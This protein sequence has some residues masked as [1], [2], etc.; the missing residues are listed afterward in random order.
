M[1][2]LVHVHPTHACSLLVPDPLD[3]L[4]NLDAT[5]LQL[6]NGMRVLMKHTT[7]MEDELFLTGVAPGGLTE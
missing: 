3:L 1:P 6:V 7:H 4:Q 5:E 2:K